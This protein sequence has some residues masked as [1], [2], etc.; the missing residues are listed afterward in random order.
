V[1]QT[2]DAPRWGSRRGG[3][4]APLRP[5]VGA[6]PPARPLT[7]LPGTVRIYTRTGDTGETSLFGGGR[8]SKQH[9]RVTAYGD[10][11]ELNACIGLAASGEPVDFER[12]LLLLIQRDLLAIGGQLATPHPDQVREA[13]E[14]TRI[15]PDRIAY[16][17]AN[18]DRADEALSPLRAFVVP[19]GTPKAAL[20]HH[21]RTVCR[22]AERSTVALNQSEPVP[23]VI[24][25]YLNRLSDL[26]FMLARLANQRADIPDQTW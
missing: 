16:L 18:I 9:A 2:V 20:L 25:Q 15:A 23:P 7:Y 26:L 6:L 12:D 14:K 5:C 4:S 13:L 22:R 19:G 1:R 3:L 10:V 11:D 8:V 24:L 17:E 21:A